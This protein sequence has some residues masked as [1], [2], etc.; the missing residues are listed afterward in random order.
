MQRSSTLRNIPCLF[1]IPGIAFGFIAMFGE[2]IGLPLPVIEW[3][4]RYWWIV[5][6]IGLLLLWAFRTAAAIW[7][8]AGSE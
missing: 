4:G 2:N 8:W 3:C 1:P 6:A 5:L 7:G